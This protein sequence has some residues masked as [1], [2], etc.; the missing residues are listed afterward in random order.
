MKYSWT[1]FLGYCVSIAIW[2]F[3]YQILGIGIWFNILKTWV[4]TQVFLFINNRLFAL[5]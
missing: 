2:Y 4:F 5:V 3:Q 1:I